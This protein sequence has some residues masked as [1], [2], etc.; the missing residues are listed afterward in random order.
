MIAEGGDA[1]ANGHASNTIDFSKI[2]YGIW[3]QKLVLFSV[4][5]FCL[6]ACVIYL[7]VSPLGYTVTLQV[8]PVDD[9]SK[10]IKGTLGD[11]A[12]AAGIALPASEGGRENSFELFLQN[13]YGRETAID[14][15]RDQNLMQMM[16]SRE[17]D[18]QGRKW[19]NPSGGLHGIAHAVK[20]LLGF[21]SEPWQAPNGLRVQR[22]I[23]DN[24]RI[25]RD[26]KSPIVTI[27]MNHRDPA[28]G[29]LFLSKL[30]AVDDG[31]LRERTLLRTSKYIDY[32]N[33]QLEKVTNDDYRK[34]LIE[35][36]SDQ[37]KH[38]M[39]ASS[40]SIAYAADPFEPATSSANPTSPNAPLLLTLS[41]AAGILLGCFSAL[42]WD[43]FDQR[44]GSRIK[45]VG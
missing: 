2:V 14:L 30:H 28:F 38:R 27:V 12:S 44:S 22:F 43:I 33:V 41:I 19:F 39:I 3:R 5:G 15:A 16:F 24:V 9:Q 1:A 25:S 29:V 45:Q 36:L 35:L 13:I 42:F 17:W 31:R 4:I 26:L 37:E 6:I 10:Q 8:V 23:V 11:L 32:L 18:S 21:P 34:A 7:H 40:R 20:F